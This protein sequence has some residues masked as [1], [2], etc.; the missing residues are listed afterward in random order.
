MPESIAL[1]CGFDDIEI[2]A[3]L[4]ALALGGRLALLFAIIGTALAAFHFFDAWI[5]DRK[6][7]VGRH[8]RRHFGG[9]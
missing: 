4:S 1:A 2:D 6:S 5:A 8:R 9:V 3:L 7:P